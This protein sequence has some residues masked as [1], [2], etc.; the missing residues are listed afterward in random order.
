MEITSLKS[1]TSFVVR[2]LAVVGLAG[3]AWA[4]LGPIADASAQQIYKIVGPDGRV[5][6]SDKPPLDA[7]TKASTAP[8]VTASRGGGTSIASLPF[9]VRQ[10]ATRYPVTLYSA[11]G[12]Q[13]C[14]T[15]RAMLVSRGIPFDEKTVTSNEDFEAL[16]RVSGVTTLPLLTIGSQQLKGFGES[17]WNQFLDAAGYPKTSQLPPNYL[18]NPATPLV[19][20]ET[21]KS[22]TTSAATPAAAQRQPARPQAPETPPPSETADNPAGIK[23]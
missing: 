9:E 22:T 6:F 19:A 16:K 2:P 7:N 4:A 8:V 18:P 12:C 11:P 21:P 15:G 5:T 10:A 13:T 20:V 17:E 23:F 1:I 3:L 14:A